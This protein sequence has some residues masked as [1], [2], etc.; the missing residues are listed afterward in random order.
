MYTAD[1]F[2]C[3]VYIDFII[4]RFDTKRRFEKLEQ[5]ICEDGHRDE[6]SLRA[7]LRYVPIQQQEKIQNVNVLIHGCGSLVFCT[8]VFATNSQSTTGVPL[9]ADAKRQIYSIW[10][11]QRLAD[12]HQDLSR[13]E[14]QQNDPEDTTYC[15]REWWA[16]NMKLYRISY[17]EHD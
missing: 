13:A 3:G 7:E 17:I 14:I 1:Q 11:R 5:V 15:S 16:G 8:I 9:W 4:F 6:K 10:E 2:V 12:H